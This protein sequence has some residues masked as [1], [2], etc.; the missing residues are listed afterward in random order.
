MDQLRDAGGPVTRFR[1]GPKWL[2]PP[3]VVAPSPEAIRD[4]LSNKDGAID[5]TTRVFTEFRRV[6]GANLFDLPYEPWL[7]RRRTL[8]PVFTKQQ[9]RQFGGH[10]AEAAESVAVAWQDDATVN[11]DAEC[12]MLT[13][14]A[15]GRS[16][17]GRDL[18]GH[19]ADVN[20]PLRVALTYV[21]NRAVRPIRAPAWLPTPARRRA[22]AASATL[23]RLTNDIV[24]ECRVDPTKEAPLVRALLAATD[25][26]THKALSDREIAEELIVFLFAGHDTTA[27][28]L[29]YALWQLGHHPEVQARVAAEVARIPR[30]TLTPDDVS[31]LPYTVQVLRAALRVRPPT[32]TGSRLTTRDIEVAGYRVEA[33]RRWSSGASP[34]SGTRRCGS[35]H[36]GSTPI[37]SVRPTSKVATAGSTCHSVAAPGRASGII[38]QCWSRLWVWPRS[39]GTRRLVRWTK[40]FR[41]LR[42]SPW[43]RTGR[44]GRAF[45][46]VAES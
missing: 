36:C 14:R 11:L 18:S 19:A 5:K 35:G 13:L 29:T 43:S 44:S 3:I 10:M 22:R 6:V 40:S 4:I 7:P 25:P 1:L 34:C 30:R 2:M 28:T 23:H 38:S 33:V 21:A 16:V 41:W 39:S 31:Q 20:E 42:R 15:L 12:R 32:P 9:V 46:A 17:L 24:R 8:R 26:I 37:G 45:V 27:T